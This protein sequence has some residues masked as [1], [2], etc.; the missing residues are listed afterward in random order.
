MRQE[1][2]DCLILSGIVCGP[3]VP[4]YPCT[5]DLTWLA[6]VKVSRRL[7]GA[8]LALGWCWLALVKVSHRLVGAGCRLEL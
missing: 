6:L 5:P 7:A 1:I 3:L 8:G 2:D 4:L